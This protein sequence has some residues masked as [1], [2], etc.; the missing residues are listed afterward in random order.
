M[1]EKAYKAFLAAIEGENR[2]PYQEEIRGMS[3]ETITPIREVLE[4][5]DDALDVHQIAERSGIPLSRVKS[6]ITKLHRYGVV[7]RKYLRESN[8]RGTGKRGRSPEY[9]YYLI[10][11]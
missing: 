4:A 5:T 6:A 11:D 2:H 3:G 9:G 1:I 7:G 8:D 10:G